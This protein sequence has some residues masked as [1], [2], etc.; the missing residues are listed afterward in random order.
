MYNIN[1]SWYNDVNTFFFYV[2]KGEPVMIQYKWYNSETSWIGHF[3]AVYSFDE[4]GAW[5]SDSISVK[6]IR[7]PY[8]DLFDDS[9]KY[10]E[11]SFAVVEKR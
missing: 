10:T 5:V 11:F 1:L 6:R 3:V 7:I 9:G 8:D 4:N 2:S